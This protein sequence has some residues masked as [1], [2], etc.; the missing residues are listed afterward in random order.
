ML[1]RVALFLAD[2]VLS[3]DRNIAGLN[4]VHFVQQRSDWSTKLLIASSE[5]LWSLIDL[6]LSAAQH[7]FLAAAFL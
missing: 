5:L 2:I 6:Y 7:S 4:P 1:T 3:D